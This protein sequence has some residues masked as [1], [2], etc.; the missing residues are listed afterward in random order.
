MKLRRYRLGALVLFG[1]QLSA[2]VTWQP[3]PLNRQRILEEQQPERVRI[4]EADGTLIELRNPRV[5]RDSLIAEASGQA[6]PTQ[7]GT[8]TV[9]IPLAEVRGL[10][11]HHFDLWGTIGLIAGT[12]F[13]LGLACTAGLV[14]S[15]LQ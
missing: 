4:R 7:F 3:V 13:G 9:R 2:C 11:I 10:E 1:L 6:S 8:E 5:E 12:W 15:G 14:C